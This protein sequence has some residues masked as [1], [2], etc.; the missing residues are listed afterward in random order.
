[1]RYLPK[2]MVIVISF[3]N[4][5]AMQWVKLTSKFDDNMALPKRI[6]EQGAKK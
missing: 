5:Q 3:N 4:V 6:A 1:V 2:N